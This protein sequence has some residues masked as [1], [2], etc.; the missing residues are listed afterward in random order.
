MV[1]MELGSIQ[2]DEERARAYVLAH[3]GLREQAR[4]GGIYGVRPP[5]KEVVK[6]LEAMQNP[7]GGF[8]SAQVSGNPSSIDTTCYIL[9]QLKDMPPLAGSPMAS[10]AVAFL[11]RNQGTDGSW[12][13]SEAAVAL[14]PPWARR[15]DP[16]AAAYLTAN[17]AYTL[18]TLEPTQR[19]PVAR[20]AAWLRVVGMEEP[21]AAYTQTLALA[22]GV[23]YLLEGPAST[24]ASPLLRALLERQ[25]DASDLAW[26]LTIALEVGAGGACLLPLARQL[27]QLAGMQRED[28][29]WPGEAGFEVEA[30]LAALRVFRG[31]GIR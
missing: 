25:L 4:L 13:E 27:V 3:G 23:R 9:A 19:D 10:R 2:L 12:Q 14:A 11:R 18:L 1:I 22:W 5:A 29:A 17:A 24:G 16:M 21:A 8:P 30:T 15:G 6:A 20:A 31:Y 26:W 28:G 7:D